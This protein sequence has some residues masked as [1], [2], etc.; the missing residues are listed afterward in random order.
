[1]NDEPKDNGLP[2][3]RLTCTTTGSVR[4]ETAASI[5]GTS[6]DPRFQVDVHY[7][8][9]RPYESAL[10]RAARDVIAGG[11]DWWLHIDSD[12]YWTA[13]PFDA[14]DHDKDLIGYPAPIYNPGGGEGVPVMSFM[15][16]HI[17]DPADETTVTAAKANGK[18]TRVDFIASGA[19]LIRVAALASAG[20]AQPFARRYDADGVAD[21]GGDIEFCRKWREAKLLVW[22]D[23]GNVCGHFKSVDLLLVM[24]D[25]VALQRQ[26]IEQA[27]AKGNGA[28]KAGR[29]VRPS[30]RL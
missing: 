18:L 16:W 22:A 15:A 11:F 30:G 20:I 29:I 21:R 25:M 7:M 27:G 9:D 19:F 12:Q 3:V 24:Q 4:R 5:M 17:S 2:K 6:R 14:I 1:M 10:N 8:N 23:F 26:A 13:N 28:P